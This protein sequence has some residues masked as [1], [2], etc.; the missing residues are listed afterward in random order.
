MH[1]TKPALLLFISALGVSA[2]A[3]TVWQPFDLDF[4]GPFA[5]ETDDSPNPFLD[6]RLQVTF[7][8]GDGTQLTVPGFYDGDGNGGGEGNIWRVRFAPDQ[9]GQWQYTAS[10]RAGDNVAVELGANAGSAS[11]FDGLAG[12]FTVTPRDSNAPGFLSQGRLEYV[13]EHYLKFRDGDYW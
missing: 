4:A 13:G 7:T 12:S 3:Q 2:H 1:Y 6:Y 10:F 9:A 5:N 8:R 11:D